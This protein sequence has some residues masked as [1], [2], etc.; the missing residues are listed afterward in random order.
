MEIKIIDSKN[1][2]LVR[3]KHYNYNF[4]KNTGFFARWGKNIEDDPEYSFLG[5]EI[6]DIEISAGKC[7]ASCR[8]CYK[9]NNGSL[10]TQNM[11]LETFKNILEKVNKYNQLT[12]VAFGITDINTNPDFFPIMEHCVEKGIV[13]NYTCNGWQVTEEIAKKTSE[14]CGAVAVSVYNKDVSY[15]AIKRF[16]D[17]GMNQVNIHFMLS[18][19]TYEKALEIVSDMKTDDRLSKMNAIVFLAYKPKGTHPNKFTT[20]IDREK[21]KNLISYCDSLGVSYG[22]DSCSAGMY[23][24]AIQDDVEKVEKSQ[25]VESCESSLFSGYINVEGKYFHCSFAEGQGAWKEGIDVVDSDDF[26]KDVWNH[27]LTEKYRS[28]SINSAKKSPYKSCGDCRLCMV[29]P[30]INPW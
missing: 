17:A 1:K 6:L 19:E 18:E 24:S 10:P 25:Y 29:F 21:Y 13:P 20:I 27:S 28:A 16:T 12:Q 26:I 15:N 23:I 2:K 30:S 5:P 8:F 11:N 22:M 4:D 9:S 3:S 7:L 14:I